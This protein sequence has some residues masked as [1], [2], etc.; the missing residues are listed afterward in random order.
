[1]LYRKITKR[2]EEYQETRR[3]YNVIPKDN[4]AH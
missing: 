1:M 3:H 4:E 2:I